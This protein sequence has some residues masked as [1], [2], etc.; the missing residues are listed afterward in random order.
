MPLLVALVGLLPLAVPLPTPPLAT[1]REGEDV[2]VR[3]LD[4]VDGDTL[5]VELEGRRV[6]LRLSCVDT[7]EKLSAR[8]SRSPT[9]PGTVFGHE[10]VGWTRDLFAE[11]GA[12]PELVLRFPGAREEDVYG[13][14]L[15]HVLLPDGSDFNLRLVQEGRSPY[16]VKYGRCRLADAAFEAAQDEAR[17]ARRGIWDPR[18][19]R[20]RTPGA[21]SA[22]RPYDRLLPWW[23][24]RAAAIDDFREQ[25]RERPGEV[26][27]GEDA[28]GLAAARSRARGDREARVRLFVTIA[29]LEEGADGALSVVLR[30]GSR[31]GGPR[32]TLT[33]EERTELEPLLRGTLGEFRQN[34]LWVRA[35]LSGTARAPRLLDAEWTV[36]APPFPPR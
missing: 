3:L 29:R 12:H 14:L 6:T 16:F 17:Q 32:V 11:H 21:P 8:P 31:D 15:C 30:G 20:S 34:F 35:R 4:V 10:T 25:A 24:A 33:R 23:R 2:R 13:R 7:E 26:L 27:A 18:T 28:D 22:V 1:V 5:H 9:K 19:N 36:A